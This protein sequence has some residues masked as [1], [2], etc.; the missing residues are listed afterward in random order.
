M[1]EATSI[2]LLAG[3][4]IFGGYFVLGAYNHFRNRH[5]L[6]GYAAA[7]GAPMPMASVLGT[8]ALLG[9]G[10]LSV[11]TGVLPLLGLALLALFLLGVTPLMH[12]FWK[13]QDPTMR[14]EETLNFSRNAA[15][16]GAVFALI[17]VPL[18][19]DYSVPILLS[20]G[21]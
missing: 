12:A 8:G 21:P 18:P 1:T 16:F 14:M 11:I 3:R 7:K 10:G 4:L 2:A 19:W 5:A 20:G 6:A 9:L 17:A 13:V 15:L